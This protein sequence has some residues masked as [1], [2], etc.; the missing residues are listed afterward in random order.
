VNVQHR[1]A[2]W[3][4]QRGVALIL[5]LSFLVFPGC[6]GD[7][8]PRSSTP[9]GNGSTP[10]SGAPPSSASLRSPYTVITGPNVQPITVNGDFA[11]GYINDLLTSVTICVP[12]TTTCQTLPNILVDT[13]SSG[14]RI[15]GSQLDLALPAVMSESAPLGECF[16]FV[17]AYVWGPVV[18]ADV[19]LA[20]ERAAAVPIQLIGSPDSAAPPFLCSSSGLPANDTVEALGANGILGVGLFAYDCGAACAPQSA[21]VPAIYF[22][23]SPTSASCTPTLVPLAEQVSNP[24]WRFPQ[25]NNGVIIALPP[26]DASGAASVT[27]TLVFGIGTA[28]NNGLGNA[29]VYTT[30][31]RGEFIAFYNDQA[32]PGSYLDTGSS[33]LFILDPLTLGLPTCAAHAAAAGE[34]CPA[35]TVSYTATTLGLNGTSGPVLFSITNA[36]TLASSNNWAFNDLAAPFTSRRAEALALGL[37]FF[38]GRNVFVAIAGQSTPA[39]VGPYWAY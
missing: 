2:S 1:S 19:V 22:Q 29:Q 4:L 36:E 25:D 18:T 39:G 8:T 26:I 15:I 28:A 30:D 31:A 34:Y 7:A 12:G 20:D 16:E 27:G 9:P 33:V 38:F 6:G 21:A 32:Y 37:P 14:L 11:Y 17:D 23:C 35:S 24:V 3:W 13:G 5:V 10:G